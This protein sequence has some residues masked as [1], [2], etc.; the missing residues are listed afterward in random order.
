MA[1]ATPGI[2]EEA[3]PTRQ[4]DLSLSVASRFSGLLATPVA[5]AI[6]HFRKAAHQRKLAAL[7]NR[8]LRDAG[9]DPSLAGRGKAAVVSAATLR[10][11]QSLSW[12]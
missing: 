1:H 3:V 5:A 10:H 2:G 7:S 4:A 9:V 6:D 8:Q 11:L 12:G